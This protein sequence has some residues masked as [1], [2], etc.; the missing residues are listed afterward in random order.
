MA[1]E[2]LTFEIKGLK[3]LQQSFSQSPEIAEPVFREAMGRSK[4]VL[5]ANRINPSNIP[6]I[7]GELARRWSTDFNSFLLKTKPDVEYARA[8]QFGM[9]PSPGRYVPAIG[10]RLI[11]GDKIGTW[12]GFKGRFFMEKIFYA[13]KDDI[14]KIFKN[15]T[16]IIVERISK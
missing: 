2:T 13:S 9:P 10:R 1:K 6:W 8:V 7:T 11:N 15:A 4:V 16:N 14:E 3:K 5:D 12:P